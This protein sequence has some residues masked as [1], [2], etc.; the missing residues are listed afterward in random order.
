MLKTSEI[1]NRFLDYFV[2]NGHT[3]VSSSSL[4]PSND[5]S[6]LFTTAGMVQFKDVFT[7][8]EKRPYQRATTSQRCLRAGGK[9]N[10]LDNVGYTARH[11][12][13][14][15]M[16]GNFSF[17]DYFKDHAIELAWKLIVLGYELPKERLL[18]TV[19]ADD[20]EAAILWRKIAGLSED[21]IIRIATADNFWSMG[22]TGPCGPCSEIFFDHGDDVF[23]GPPGSAEA[24]GDRF[25]EIWN[26]VFMQFEQKPDGTRVALP[27]PSV[28]TG[29]GLERLAAVLQGVHN[30]Y[31]IDTFQSI[32]A[33][34]ADQ[35]AISSH[36]EIVASHRVIADHLRSCAFLIADGVLPSNEG[37]G[38]VLRRIMRRAMRHAHILGCRDTLMWKLVPALIAE[39]GAAYPE[40]VRAEM[41]IEQTLRLEEERFRDMLGRG[42]KLLA[43]ESS[44]L[45]PGE[46]L[47]G[48]AAFKL[49]DTFGFPLDL[50][51][52]ALKAQ[53][54]GVDKDG[55]EKAMAVQRQESRASWA[56][57]GDSTNDPLWF[58]LAEKHGS[59]EF[60]GY[61]TEIAEALVLA[62]L[63]AE[64]L[65]ELAE[66]NSGAEV[67]I[68]TNQTPFYAESGGQQGDTGLIEGLVDH[69]NLKVAVTN[70][71]RKIGRLNVHFGVVGSGK[72]F[73]GQSIKLTV[74]KERRRQ[75]R[76]NHSATHLLHAALRQCLG[77]HVTQKGS[78]VAPDKL[79]FDFS[80]PSP[81]AEAEIQHIN[82][83][84]NAEIRK[85]SLVT[86]HHLSIDEAMAQG[87]M[88][89]FGEK[90]ADVVRVVSMGES[91][92]EI[93]DEVTKEPETFSM[94][95][96][97][98]THVTRTGDIGY[99]TIIS[100]TG[101]SAG[102]R[103][104]E[105][106]SGI[107][108]EHYANRIRNSLQLLASM[109]KTSQDKVFF[110]ATEI[111][112]QNKKLEQEIRSLKAKAASQKVIDADQAETIG[113]TKLLCH[114]F[115][116]ISPK[117]LRTLHE[118]LRSNL[119]SGILCLA[120]TEGGRVSLLVSISNDLIN[121]FN[122]V[123]LVKAAVIQI[124]GQGGGGRP[125]F[126]QGGGIDADK[127]N[128]AFSAIRKMLR[129]HN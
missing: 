107:A 65:K 2:E 128:E 91:L 109:F 6:L 48:S 90:Y 47:S 104:I 113:G 42:L 127:I 125:G 62:I 83:L 53:G 13:F 108:A 57:S 17:G 115:N 82:S 18:V 16:L 33:A 37:R 75:L 7:G 63:D 103:R 36:K 96:C 64:T 24:D 44:S 97:G 32:I 80:H 12:T 95:L 5:P 35:L 105:A 76:A 46:K 45:A 92:T 87:A 28:D 22:D 106:L 31:E 10:D 122:A 88:A 30:N 81:L 60:M 112:A 20:D 54:Y 94:E 8:A 51:E 29:M 85:N 74:A 71:L 41:L 119:Q 67:L 23:G 27:R 21:K 26:L 93:N 15:E 124:G 56:G 4:V 84:V 117:E 129:S 111:L 86:T 11:H 1:R 49:Y 89:L 43:E 40:L 69:S 55:F 98:G 61:E 114:V 101:V 102:I 78:L 3:R 79:R 110:K 58:Q 59:T 66:A 118:S 68:L 19:Y 116:D 38:Y 120:A 70:T 9:H 25:I 34:I 39:M 99:F 100:E 77:K 52:D 72:I 73:L 126:A 50:T 123:E 121:K 14:F